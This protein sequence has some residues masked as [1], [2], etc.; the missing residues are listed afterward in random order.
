[1]ARK[2]A[3]A[4]PPESVPNE[5]GPSKVSHTEANGTGGGEEET[6][7]GLASEHS[8]RLGHLSHL[9]VSSKVQSVCAGVILDFAA[10]GCCAK[11]RLRTTA[12]SKCASLDSW[13]VVQTQR[14]KKV[15][16][17]PPSHQTR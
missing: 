2:S 17:T 12:F 5:P 1:M 4:T 6:V 16:V 15:L 9:F 3:V 8:L 7:E 14:C 11:L 10:S 13:G